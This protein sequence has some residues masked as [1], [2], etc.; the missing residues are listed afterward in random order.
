MAPLEP[1]NDGAEAT[2]AVPLKKVAG[3]VVMCLLR[4]GGT[5]VGSIGEVRL[6]VGA[7]DDYW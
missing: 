4:L 5:I 3:S 2:L 6:D 1:G 7:H